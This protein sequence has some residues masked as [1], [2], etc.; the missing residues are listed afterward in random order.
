MTL[1]L[2]GFCQFGRSTFCLGVR[3]VNLGHPLVWIVVWQLQMGSFYL[4]SFSVLRIW[5]SGLWL[6]RTFRSF[7]HFR[8]IL[9]LAALLKMPLV[10]GGCLDSFPAAPLVRNRW[11]ETF[12]PARHKPEFDVMA[13]LRRFVLVPSFTVPPTVR[14]HGCGHVNI[15]EQELQELIV[16]DKA[17]KILGDP[18]NFP[19]NFH[20]KKDQSIMDAWIKTTDNPM[21]GL[22]ASY[23]FQHQIPQSHLLQKGL[24]TTLL[25]DESDP[26]RYYSPWEMIACVGWPATTFLERVAI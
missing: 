14:T 3:P 12:A 2:G 11:M 23:G 26:V 24:Y 9:T 21:T 13:R 18:A 15:S 16:D 8:P 4:Q 19:D 5:K 22:V 1:G 7:G 20:K 17:R 25:R 10:Q 6:W